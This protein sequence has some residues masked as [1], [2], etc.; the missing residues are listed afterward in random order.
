MQ[1]WRRCQVSHCVLLGRRFS[2]LQSFN[3]AGFTAEEQQAARGLF[4]GLEAALEAALVSTVMR[5]C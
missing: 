1:P 3:G 4:G 2:S 5:P